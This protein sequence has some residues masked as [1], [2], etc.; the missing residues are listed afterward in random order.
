MPLPRAAGL[1]VLWLPREEIGAVSHPAA[2]SVDECEHK[3]P[4]P[5][6]PVS[7]AETNFSP[8]NLLYGRELYS[9]TLLSF[10]FAVDSSTYIEPLQ[11][12]K[13]PA[14]L[15]GAFRELFR[16]TF[17]IKFTFPDMETL[18]PSVVLKG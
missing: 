4:A 12:Y 3:L 7:L 6:W 18:S 14:L 2:D 10:K 8:L 11:A 5:P 16:R 15:P 13:G 9:Q 1:A 17:D